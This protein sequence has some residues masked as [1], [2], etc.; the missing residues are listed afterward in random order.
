M[1]KKIPL[2]VGFGITGK[3]LINHLS[4][5]HKEL[6]LIEDSADNFDFGKS[7]NDKLNLIVNPVIDE[8][9][10]N[11]VSDIYSSPGIPEDHIVLSMANEKKINVLPGP[12]PFCRARAS[13]SLFTPK[14]LQSFLFKAAHT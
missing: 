4:K 6:Y 5:S 12:P 13:A 9:L 14:P 10:F 3:S 2:V 8:K 7:L 1:Q 11:K